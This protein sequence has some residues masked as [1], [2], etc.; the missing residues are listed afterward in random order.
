MTQEEDDIIFEAISKEEMPN[1][2]SSGKE[3][4]PIGGDFPSLC[5]EL[6]ERCN[7]THFMFPYDKEKVDVA[8][9]IYSQVLNN[10]NDPLFLKELRS[11]AI[12][13]LHVKFTTIKLY[14]TLTEVCN[15]ANF[16]N[17]N[18]NAELLSMANDL[19]AQ[20]LENADDIETLEDIEKQTGKL[21]QQLRIREEEKLEIQKEQELQKLIIKLENANNELKKRYENRRILLVGTCIFFIGIIIMQI[22]TTDLEFVLSI[23]LLI[24]MG[25]A[26]VIVKAL[27]EN[28]IRDINKIILLF[29]NKIK[30]LEQ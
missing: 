30:S 1:D 5:D 11:K 8:N 22:L 10:K 6:M 3:K 24:L 20:V 26:F 25:I 17:E 2:Y 12:R 7:P 4:R 29:E 23:I 16:M 13:Q 27:I 18:Y 15:P 9:E 14:N 21:K 28:E 19:Y